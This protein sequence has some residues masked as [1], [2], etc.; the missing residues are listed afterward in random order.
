MNNAARFCDTFTP[1]VWRRL[2]EDRNAVTGAPEPVIFFKLRPSSRAAV[3][4]PDVHPHP[5][6]R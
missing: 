1:R 5:V 6:V 3:Q 2:L 4:S